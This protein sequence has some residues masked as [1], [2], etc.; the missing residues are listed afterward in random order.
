MGAGKVLPGWGIVLWASQGGFHVEVLG[1]TVFCQLRGKIMRELVRET[2][3]VAVGDD[4]RIERNADG[5]GIIVERGKRRTV[6]SRTTVGKLGVEQV[7][8]ANV[9]QLVVVS[10][11]ADP[12]FRER[13]V[14]RYLVAAHKGGLDA[15]LCITKIDL[16]DPEVFYPHIATYE[17]LGYPIVVTSTTMPYGI[18]EVKAALRGKLSV[19]S[20][21]SGAGKSS[22]LNVLQPGLQLR[23]GEVSKKTGKGGHTTTSARIY[24]LDFGGRVVDTPGLRE[25]QVWDL[26]PEEAAE[27]FVEFAEFLGKCRYRSCRHHDEPACAIRDA[28]ERGVIALTR[29]DSYLRLFETV[30]DNTRR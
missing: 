9:D 29:Y 14:D 16:V 1:E 26:M 3:P 19:L 4:V 8:A 13:L 21:P 12:E 2:T 22:L 17:K 18:E 20:G 6:L 11:A 24:S 5:T 30:G 25:L 28:V 27:H 23:V 15:I 10:S 7:L